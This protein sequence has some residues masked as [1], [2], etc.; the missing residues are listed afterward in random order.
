[1]KKLI[2]LLL[3]LSLAILSFPACTPP[4]E[5]PPAGEDPVIVPGSFDY[6][7]SDLSPFITLG[8]HVFPSLSISVQGIPEI[9]DADVEKE[10]HSYFSQGSYYAPKAGDDTVDEGDL[11]FFSYHG[12]LLSKLNEAVS[13]GKIP[14]VDCTGM[15]YSDILALS[16]GFSGGTTNGITSITVGSA[17]FIAGFEDGLVGKTVSAQGEQNP[18]RLHLTFPAAYGSA[19]LA[20]QEVIFFCRL[21][22]IGDKNLGLLNKDTVTLPLL[23]DLLGLSGEDAYPSI[24]A[25]LASIRDGLVRSRENNLYNQKATAI[26]TALAEAAVFPQLP[27]AALA[28]SVR[29]FLDRQLAEFRYLYETSPQYYQYLFGNEAPSDALVASYY[30]YSRDN[31]MTEMKE[32][33]IPAVKAELVYYY[34]LRTYAVSLSEG[35]IAA[36]RQKYIDLYGESI[37]E[38]LS[39]AEIHAQFLRDKVTEGL[40]DY[41]EENGRIAY[42][43]AA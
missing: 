31:Y 38:G 6:M 36:A 12:V 14:D 27:D 18:V 29:Q 41:L 9:T 43:S 24:D 32:D 7:S 4:V 26:Y 16:L 30:G 23:N 20:G 1:M 34:L 13:A 2:V 37:F 25:C 33:C 8:E 40:I 42:T 5:M 17:N 15:S 11:L 3:L 39:D 21:C 19:E 22:Y 28:L 10:F 35:E